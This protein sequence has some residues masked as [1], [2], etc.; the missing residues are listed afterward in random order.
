MPRAYGAV[1]GK[2]A[3]RGA[4]GAPGRRYRRVR[5]HAAGRVLQR[6]PLRAR[7]RDQ[8][9]A[10]WRRRG[11]SARVRRLPLDDSATAD[12]YFLRGDIEAYLGTRWPVLDDAG[13][14][15]A[16]AVYGSLATGGSL[17]A[18]VLAARI[19][20]RE[21]G[22]RTGPTTSCTATARS[23]SRADPDSSWAQAQLLR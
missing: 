2:L 4:Y 21:R 9:P 7:T 3:A 20:L 16:A 19:E 22:Q 12:G 15:F 11:V 13:A 18:A 1:Q 10:L 14:R 8:G 17:D 5:C 6:L 23:R